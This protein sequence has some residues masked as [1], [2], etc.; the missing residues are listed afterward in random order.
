MAP[1]ASLLK[2]LDNVHAEPWPPFFAT[3]LLGKKFTN[4]AGTKRPWRKPAFCNEGW[5]CNQHL[6]L[7]LNITSISTSIS[8]I[9][10]LFL[11]CQ[12]IDLIIISKHWL[13]TE[14]TTCFTIIV[15][16]LISSRQ[17]WRSQ[18]TISS[19]DVFLALG[20][21]A[22][23]GQRPHASRPTTELRQRWW[24]TV[25]TPRPLRRWCFFGPRLMGFSSRHIEK[26]GFSRFHLG[27]WGKLRVTVSF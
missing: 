17:I 12:Q 2:F 23:P 16:P 26:W 15:L 19:P 20:A 18:H 4:S 22:A 9:G 24:R 3:S 13:K 25:A 27:N 1:G 7:D 14:P 21:Q 6:Q 8:S 11:T 5:T 10:F